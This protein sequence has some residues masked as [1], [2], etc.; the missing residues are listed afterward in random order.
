MKRLVVFGLLLGLCF[1]SFASPKSWLGGSGNW[2]NG[3]HWSPS[4]A[5]ANGDDI[6]INPGGTI[7]ITIDIAGPFLLNSLLISNNT[8]VTFDCPATRNFTLS[9]TSSVMPGLMIGAGSTL[10]IDG[11]NVGTNNSTLFISGGAGVIGTING[12][13][14]FSSSGGTR[15]A[16][17]SIHLDTNTG[18]SNYGIVT[19]NSGGMINVQADAGNTATSLT[20]V[21]NM[22]MKNGSVYQT[23]RSGGSFPVGTWETT[24]LAKATS[25]GTSAPTFNGASYGNLVWDC[26]LQSNITFF[27]KDISFNDVNLI[28]TN[29][30][31]ASGEIRIKTSNSAGLW[32]MSINGNLTIA[33]GARLVTTAANVTAGNGGK[34]HLKG[35]LINAGTIKADGPAT[36]INE[37]ELNGIANQ[38]VSVTDSLFGPINFLMNNTA[39]ATLLTPITLS[40]ALTLT[41]GNITTTSSHLLIMAAGSSSTPGSSSSFVN[42]PMKKIGN[43][44]FIFPVGIGVTGGIYAAIRII[45][46]SGQ[47]ITDEFTAEYK[48]ANPQT[49]PYGPSVNSPL[50]HVS[51][52]EYWKLD[53]NVGSSDKRISVL[54]HLLSFCME[55]NNTY[56]CRWNGTSAWGKLETLPLSIVPVGP[57]E[58][59]ELVT[60]ITIGGFAAPQNAFTLGTD[61]IFINNPLPI[62]LISFDAAKLTNIK[63]SLNWELAAYCSPTA[64]FEVQRTG[65]N[66]N[67]VTIAT[68]DGSATNRFYSYTDNDL[69]TGINYYRLKM[70]DENGTITYSRTVAIVNGIKGLLLT[71]LIPT[72]I[73]NTA[74]LTVTSSGSEKLDIAIIDMQGR[75][76]MKQNY[77]VNE[78]NTVILLPLA[79]LAAGV[80]QLTG[81]S[82]GGR[83]NMIRFIKQ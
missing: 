41:S 12:T 8:T 29:R 50:D 44:D 45:N 25:V 19:V 14:I 47:Q 2:S 64:K 9:S 71:S 79:G 17:V 30:T 58:I 53:Q 16:G 55:M 21:P 72:I 13:L 57:Y 34:I 15:G 1:Y 65:A 5:P 37:L 67:F 38:M 33:P 22:V 4:G 31:D 62:N 32:T 56:I 49:S 54:V 10:T 83:T 60:N 73:N 75:T 26:P 18:V 48:R 66:K 52:V 77:T 69:Q 42:G 59:G 76:I 11:S 28:S 6:T 63:S 43:T 20:P 78:G 82:A 68:I 7:I 3:A 24:S 46:V 61:L 27:N 70:T 74:T 36:S 39:G 35:N 23:S 81:A 51:Y 80:Y 40:G